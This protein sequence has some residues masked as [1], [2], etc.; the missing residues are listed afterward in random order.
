MEMEPDEDEDE[1]GFGMPPAPTGLPN[2]L[3]MPSLASFKNA[4]TAPDPT[5]S[6]S[7]KQKMEQLHKKPKNEPSEFQK[8]LFQKN[9]EARMTRIQSNQ[10]NHQEEQDET[11]PQ[12]FM[13]R[14]N[15]E[16][17]I[18]YPPL[19]SQAND[20]VLES[21]SSSDGEDQP[22]TKAPARLNQKER[23]ILVP[24]DAKQAVLTEQQKQMLEDQKVFEQMV[25]CIKKGE[26][27]LPIAEQA[28]PLQDLNE[29]DDDE[30]I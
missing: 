10:D 5:S 15:P 18:P 17:Q 24:M 8:Q 11:E 19:E 26:T 22:Q 25:E 28:G 6:K 29:E 2:P 4:P 14:R 30:P 3:Q 12:M 27:Q 7:M 20:L 16:I 9:H 13:Q 23:M 1:D 21:L